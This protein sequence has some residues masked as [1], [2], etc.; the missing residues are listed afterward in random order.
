MCIPI[1][2]FLGLP[3]GDWRDI[4]RRAKENVLGIP[5]GPRGMSHRKSRIIGHSRGMYFIFRWN[6]AAS[7][8]MA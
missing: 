3:F 6:Y 8:G 5:A 7:N 4:P 2:E 1:V